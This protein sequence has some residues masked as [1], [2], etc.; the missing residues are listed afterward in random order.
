MNFVQRRWKWEKTIISPS[1]I[2]S[3]V[4]RKFDLSRQGLLWKNEATSILGQQKINAPKL[5]SH[6]L[7]WLAQIS[8][9]YLRSFK[10]ILRNPLIRLEN[11][12]VENLLL[13]PT[14]ALVVMMVYYISAPT[15]SDFYSV[16]WC[17]WCYKCHSKG[18]H[19]SKNNGILWNNFI[20]RWPPPVL[21]LW[22][23]Y[24]DFATDFGVSTI[25]E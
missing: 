24:S 10:G 23:P 18:S 20:K 3:H 7:I 16:H 9:T 11:F 25:S 4:L 8:K 21:H 12:F 13:A 2:S 1:P 22:N 5:N 14:G 15:F 19:R 6:N 17:N